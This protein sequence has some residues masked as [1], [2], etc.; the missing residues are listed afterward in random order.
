VS[1]LRASANARD[2]MFAAICS[3]TDSTFTT[4]TPGY[5]S[6]AAHLDRC[7]YCGLLAGHPP[8]HYSV[9]PALPARVRHVPPAPQ[10]PP[11]ERTA[12]RYTV[13]SPRGPP[14]RRA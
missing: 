2:P 8:L 12:S 1:Q 7:G 4:H 9:P 3:A 14:P 10:A 6:P 13:A 11:E 5:T